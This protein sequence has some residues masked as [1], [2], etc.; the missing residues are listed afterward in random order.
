MLGGIGASSI[1][2][3]LSYERVAW[4]DSLRDPS[5]KRTWLDQYVYSC[6]I[7]VPALLL[8]ERRP[9]FSSLLTC[10]GSGD[11]SVGLYAALS[12][13]AYGAVA[14]A[15]GLPGPPS[16]VCSSSGP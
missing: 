9:E 7:S 15:I 1:I 11:C 10:F 16:L 2:S 6:W 5:P 4:K 8:S 14:L 13:C 3:V 12:V